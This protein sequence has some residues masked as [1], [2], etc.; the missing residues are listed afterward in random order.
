[1]SPLRIVL[2]DMDWDNQRPKHQ[3]WRSLRP[4][5]DQL[6]RRPGQE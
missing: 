1:M 3:W 5:F 2:E 4:V 6:S